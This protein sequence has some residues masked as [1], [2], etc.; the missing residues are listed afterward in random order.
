M[1]DLSLLPDPNKD[2]LGGLG[3]TNP[4]ALMTMNASQVNDLLNPRPQQEALIKPSAEAAKILHQTQAEQ[5]AQVA[6][7][8]R[9]QQQ[10]LKLAE[11]KRRREQEEYEANIKQAA[12]LRAEQ[13]KI[14]AAQEKAKAAQ[15]SK[16][17][18]KLGANPDGSFVTTAWAE[19]L[20]SD[21]GWNSIVSNHQRDDE[22]EKWLSTEVTNALRKELGITDENVIKAELDNA[23][24]IISK[25]TKEYEQRMRSDRIDPLDLVSSLGKAARTLY[26]G[27]G[28][29]FG[30]SD[31]WAKDQQSD[32]DSITQTYSDKILLDLANHQYQRAKT[33]GQ[34][35]NE[36]L[37]GGFVSG[38]KDAWKSGALA[39]SIVDSAGY[40]P[41]AVVGTALGA[42]ALAAGAAATGVS[43]SAIASSLGGGLLSRGAGA[44]LSSSSLAASGVGG[45]LAATDAAGGAYDSVAAL[46]FKDKKTLDTV[47]EN[48]ERVYGKGNWQ[49]LV[50]SH[51]GDMDSVK[52][53][54]AI[55]AGREAGGTAFI[56][57]APLGFLSLEATLVRGASTGLTAGIRNRVLTIGANAVEETLE[58]GLTQLA[59]NKGA[60]PVTGVSLLDDVGAAGAMGAIAG[61][62]ISAG[63]HAIS[64]YTEQRTRPTFDA[65]KVDPDKWASHGNINIDDYK[66]TVGQQLI[67][68]ANDGRKIKVGENSI[69]DLQQEAFNSYVDNNAIW[70]RMTPEQQ[71][72][73]KTYLREDYRIN[74]NDYAPYSET[75]E[76]SAW[77]S[78]NL[79]RVKSVINEDNSNADLLNAFRVKHNI[80]LNELPKGS[81]SYY[82]ALS[83][84]IDSINEQPTAITTR[85]RAVQLAQIINNQVTPNTNLTDLQKKSVDLF[86][87]NYMGANSARMTDEQQ[88]QHDRVQNAVTQVRLNQGIQNGINEQ[89]NQSQS[90]GQTTLVENG[91][92]IPTQGGTAG[93]TGSTDASDQAPQVGADGQTRTRNGNAQ[94]V[95][96]DI[97][98]Q[99]INTSTQGDDSSGGSASVNGTTTNTEQAVHAGY[100]STTTTPTSVGGQ[101][102]QTGTA[103]TANSSGQSVGQ[104]RPSTTQNTVGGGSPRV[105]PSERHTDGGST[106]AIAEKILNTSIDFAKDYTVTVNIPEAEGHRITYRTQPNVTDSAGILQLTRVSSGENINSATEVGRREDVNT[107]QALR[108]R[109]LSF[110]SSDSFSYVPEQITTAANVLI[111]QLYVE[112]TSNSDNSSN[113]DDT[114]VPDSDNAQADEEAYEKSFIKTAFANLG[115]LGQGL[116]QHRQDLRTLLNSIG[117]TDMINGLYDLLHMPQSKLTT[118]INSSSNSSTVI[119]RMHNAVH[120]LRAN[121]HKLMEKDRTQTRKQEER[122]RRAADKAQAQ[123]AK[124]VAREQ[125]AEAKRQALEIQKEQARLEKERLYTERSNERERTNHE[126]RIRKADITSEKAR[127]YAEKVEQKADQKEQQLSEFTQLLTAKQGDLADSKNRLAEAKRQLSTANKDLTTAT[128]ANR[129]AELAY[130]R[131]LKKADK[132]EKKQ[133]WLATKAE[134]A[135]AKQAVTAATKDVAIIEREINSLTGEINTLRL[136]IKTATAEYNKANTL[137][138]NARVKANQA[139]ATLDGLRGVE[140]TQ[141]SE[142]DNAEHAVQDTTTSHQELPQV[143]QVFLSTLN[144]VNTTVRSNDTTNTALVKTAQE[145]QQ[146]VNELAEIMSITPTQAKALVLSIKP[147]ANGVVYDMRYDADSDSWVLFDNNLTTREGNNANEQNQVRAIGTR[148]QRATERNPAELNAPN[149]AGVP[150]LTAPTQ[151]DAPAI[152][153]GTTETGLDTI[154]LGTTENSKILLKTSNAKTDYV[155]QVNPTGGYIVTRLGKAKNSVKPLSFTVDTSADVDNYLPKSVSKKLRGEIKLAI[156]Q[157]AGI[158]PEQ[159]DL[160]TQETD[161]VQTQQ[162]NLGESNQL[163]TARTSNESGETIVRNNHDTDEQERNLR[164]EDTTD[165]GEEQERTTQEVAEQFKAYYAERLSEHERKAIAEVAEFENVDTD[166]VYRAIADGNINFFAGR[167]ETH[168]ASAT[169]LAKELVAQEISSDVNTAMDLI[170]RLTTP[171]QKVTKED[172]PSGKS[173]VEQALDQLPEDRNII[174][175][176]LRAER[177]RL[178][179]EIQNELDTAQDVTDKAIALQQEQKTLPKT[180]TELVEQSLA[181]QLTG[182]SEDT[183][184]LPQRIKDALARILTKIR[185]TVAA[186]AMAIALA[187]GIN[188]TVPQDAMAA[189]PTETA[190]VQHIVNS[191]DNQGRPIIVADKKAGTLTLYTPTGVELNSTSALFGRAKGDFISQA[192][193]TPS[194]RYDLSYETNINNRAYGNSA[195]VLRVDGRLQGNNAGNI[196]IHRVLKGREGRLASSTAADNRISYGCINIPADFYDAHFDRDV[197]A[198][199]YVLPETDAGRTGVFAGVPAIDPTVAETKV[200]PQMD[201]ANTPQGAEVSVEQVKRAIPISE[202]KTAPAVAASPLTISGTVPSTQVAIVTPTVIGGVTAGEIVVPFNTATPAELV[203]NGVFDTQP[204]SGKI[205]SS[206]TSGGW[207]IFE[208]AAWLASAG[209][210]GKAV[211]GSLAKRRR[212]L[213]S[214]RAKQEQVEASITEQESVN[215]GVKF[216]HITQ[217]QA[218][219]IVQEHHNDIAKANK[220]DGTTYAPVNLTAPSQKSAIVDAV[221]R[222][223]WLDYLQQSSIVAEKDEYGNLVDGGKVL[224]VFDNLDIM[225]ELIDDSLSDKT[226][227][228]ANDGTFKESRKWRFTD[229]TDGTRRGVSAKI[230]NFMAGT[231]QAFDNLMTKHGIA[232]AGHEADS[233]LPSIHLAQVRSKSSGAYAQIHKVFIKP[234]V[235]QVDNLAIDLRTSYEEVEA[236]IGRLS[237]V[238]HVLNEGAEAL[239]NSKQQ[240]IDEYKQMLVN[241]TTAISATPEGSSI[242]PSLTQSAKTLTNKIADL[243]EELDTGRAMYEGSTAW[244]GKTKLPGGYTKEQA[245]QILSD[246]KNKYGEDFSKVETLAKE[247][248]VVV[249]GIR[250]FATASGVFSNA[251]LSTFN[252]TGFKEYVPLYTEQRDPLLR[253]ESANETQMSIIDKITADIPLQQARSLGL[254]KDLSRYYRE[255]ST[256]PAADGVTNLKIFAMNMAGR[257]GSK[258]W[259]NTIQ[260]LYEGTVGK[261]YSAIAQLDEETLAELNASADSGNLPGLVRVRPGQVDYLPSTIQDA[262]GRGDIKPIVAK[263]FNSSGEL[264][265]F[266]YYFTEP[267]IQ[268]EVYA[269]TDLTNTLQQV[270]IKEVSTITRVAARFMTTYKPIWNAY[271]YFRDSFERISVMLMRPVKDRNGDLVN[272]WDLS[273]AYFGNL[274]KL[275]AS[276]AAQ[277]EI[278]RFLTLGE[279][280][281]PLQNKLFEAVGNGA[282]NLMTSQTEKHSVMADLKKSQIEKLQEHSLKMLGTAFNKA[283]LGKTKQL[284]EQ[285][286]DY[287]V[288]RLTEVPQVVTALA[289]YMAYEQVGVN[290][291]ETANRIRDQYDPLRANSKTLNSVSAWFPFVRSTFSGHYNLHRS[292]SEYWGAGERQF[293]AFYTL[294]GVIGMMAIMSAMSGLFGDDDDGVPKLARLPVGTL[295][296]G[297]P[298][299]VG[300]DGVWSVP[301]GFGM[302]KLLWGVAANLWRQTNGYQTGSD[303]AASIAGLVLDNTSPVQ[304]SSANLIDDNPMAAIALSFTPTIIKPLMEL[305]F[306][307]NATF[308]NPIITTDTPKNQYRHKQDSFNT[309]ESYKSGVKWLFDAS[310]GMID[311][312]PEALKYLTEQYA[313]GPW[314]A[315]PKSILADKEEKTLGNKTTKGEYFGALATALGADMAIQPNALDVSSFTYKMAELQNELHKRY[316]VGSTN[317]DEDWEEFGDRN[318]KGKIVKRG[319]RLV[320]IRRRLEAQ[321]APENVIDYIINGLKFAK[322]HQELKT[323]AEDLARKYYE[324]RKNGGDDP[325]LK[326]SVQAA[327]EHLDELSNNYVE[328]NKRAYFE[329]LQSH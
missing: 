229:P 205:R 326:R 283:G 133:T 301:V 318:K 210:V 108:E 219:D 158:L 83:N 156:D 216:D 235:K 157:H 200:T 214:K 183:A 138:K 19:K 315:I 30:A 290:K 95:G 40:T 244:D 310:G 123:E 79:E 262:I 117:T 254:T 321:N 109:V 165:V 202:V 82:Q 110:L 324:L 197:N 268:N 57:T 5:Q 208:L 103:S 119:N 199:V 63:S 93:S 267:T 273:K 228:Q 116:S 39:S 327:Y 106:E 304:A 60:R 201:K 225:A 153:L 152:R 91:G 134:L 328:E 47:R 314:G 291:V 323:G 234:F 132:A 258:Q 292:L 24:K 213:K 155:V 195:Q 245:E 102:T 113:V 204:I 296:N 247:T 12:R 139:Q 261:P 8:D 56:T 149:R 73:F 17:G 20:L 142:V 92:T 88:A 246:L 179:R 54:L 329:I 173:R 2:L 248:A 269:T 55:Q 127:Q 177:N 170:T 135:I 288:M 50:A 22:M 41:Y 211:R 319:N 65:T 145:A 240:L 239:W 316:E 256:T 264:V 259:E 87:R 305:G 7:A 266:N 300:D 23:R 251:D 302:N 29:L 317:S 281:T 207:N 282:I 18:G 167:G 25:N 218:D 175:E 42:E 129:N 265:P 242:R 209:I 89:T 182:E 33:K 81:Q 257:I 3:I 164:G 151:T 9:L 221:S 43:S 70:A 223:M 232:R 272:R 124:R 141:T 44:V 61:G 35:P 148:V 180:T 14:R 84:A 263:G 97:A 275:S 4:T 51:N 190:T 86:I 174:D 10:Q 131:E 270:A 196:A 253:D 169:A 125:A 6:E 186:V 104:V 130:K 217:E 59:Q 308:G 274:A 68:I 271:N 193:T 38:V 13:E 16:Q 287:Y 64:A 163:E 166:T 120:H 297:L 294:G 15:A 299:P 76:T 121:V 85:D 250:Q 198:V 236:D 126:A 37:V 118:L 96:N 144:E 136:K 34:N 115:K 192:N 143:Y 11:E 1:P 280:K 249:R 74:T 46:D 26:R 48:Y 188:I 99:G 224:N 100:S 66:R 71:A 114:N 237:T 322:D 140:P 309:P 77:K 241:V 36:G 49:N 187:T 307:V 80:E 105:T 303:T 222:A 278:Y 255:G 194:G 279:L 94:S 226:Y 67:N 27:T 252:A 295:M 150:T 284:G 320:V 128:S 181:D 98:R 101:T 159:L 298:V 21:N 306:N 52:H 160:F 185:S 215:A 286:L 260:Q 58:E 230:M 172:T 311:M 189:T 238:R 168:G 62:G 206:R 231:T 90:S 111:E 277:R 31:K 53:D 112:Q 147:V 312:R 227:E 220:V 293:T 161:N 176:Y 212:K 276:G 171:V 122:S 78:G 325:D 203:A 137:A 28:I 184:N 69:Q 313:W 289:S 243:Q 45:V 162:N 72:E 32:I 285:A 191:G 154:E 146:A 107:M 178:D 233:S 75:L